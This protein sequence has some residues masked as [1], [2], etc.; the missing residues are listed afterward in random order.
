MKVIKWALAFAL[1]LGVLVIG[2]SLLLPASTHVERSI[3]IHRSP[4]QVF[5]VLDSFER[6]NQWSPWAPLDAQ[7]TYRYEGPASGKGARMSWRGNAAMG[8]GRQEILESIRDQRVTVTLDFEGSSALSTYTLTP[9]QGGTQVTWA[10]DSQHGFNPMARWFGLLFER[11]IGPDF[12]NGLQ[13]LKVLLE[14]PTP[15]VAPATNPSR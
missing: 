8:S 7:A 1:L 3:V 2:G 10:F 5:A 15:P 12:E 14:S 9:V 4:A 11:M 13:R 6:F